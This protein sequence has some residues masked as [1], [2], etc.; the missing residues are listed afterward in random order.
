MAVVDHEMS[1]AREVGDR[2]IFMD[3]GKSSR[4]TRRKRNFRQP[5]SERLK[6]FLAKVFYV[7]R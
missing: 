1:F 3:W 2:V 5:Q 4:K 6:Q 7:F